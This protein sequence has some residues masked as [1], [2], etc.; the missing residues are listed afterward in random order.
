MGTMATRKSSRSFAV[1]LSGRHL[2]RLEQ[3]SANLGGGIPPRVLV[4]AGLYALDE[5]SGRDLVR[6]ILASVEGDTVVPRSRQRKPRRRAS[7]ASK[8]SKPVG[9]AARR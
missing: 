4:A 9:A 2:D 6:V 1:N 7:K 8:A 5:L 3:I